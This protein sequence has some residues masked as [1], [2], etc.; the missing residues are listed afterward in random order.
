MRIIRVLI[1]CAGG[2]LMPALIKC[3]RCSDNFNYILIGVDSVTAGKSQDILDAYYQVPNGSDIEYSD[4]L[5]E[6]ALKENIDCIMPY[7]DEEA[8]SISSNIK[9]FNDEGILTIVSDANVLKLISNKLETYKVL[10][11]HGVR[12]PGYDVINSVEDIKNSL[13]KYQYPQKT[14]I[15]KPSN[16]RGGR[17][18]YV[19]KGK[20]TPP[21][22]LGSGMRESIVEKGELTN[23]LIE[24]AVYKN[25][26]VMPV[27]TVPAYD[28]DVLA[29]KGDVKTVV[30]RERI[31]PAGIPFQGN[32]ILSDKAIVKYCIEISNILK[33]DGLHD[34]DLMTNAEGMPCIVEVNPRPSGSI[35]AAL[36]AGIP[37]ID[38]AILSLLDEKITNVYLDSDVTVLLDDKNIMCISL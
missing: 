1:T 6:V 36:T 23:E 33:L 27:L 15:S 31:N 17:G 11:D 7:S 25:G 37:L 35:A 5:L 12:V 18:L 2:D 34:I 14:V 13:S 20:D 21:S 29:V 8:I 19:F 26:L 10:S 30:V 16:G 32:K 38:I 9:K 22:W 4:K 3:L 28:V 24:N